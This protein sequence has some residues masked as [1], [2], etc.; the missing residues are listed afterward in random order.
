M[1]AGGPTQ[2]CVAKGLVDERCGRTNS[3]ISSIQHL[4]AVFLDSISEYRSVRANFYIHNVS[5]VYLFI[6]FR[7]LFRCL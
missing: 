6:C 7:P 2:K 4:E 3:E 1:N 5:A